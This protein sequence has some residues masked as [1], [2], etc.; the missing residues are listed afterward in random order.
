MEKTLI[1]DGHPV[2]FRST[3]A[4]LLRYKAQFRRDALKDMA[5]LATVL[6]SIPQDIDENDASQIEGVLEIL[7]LQTFF[8]M[9]WV[10]AKTADPSI[11]T[12][13]VWLDKFG[14]FPIL[15]IIGELQ[16]LLFSSIRIT[17]KN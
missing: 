9:V 14:E 11:P 1:I 17:K 13:E 7:D 6:Q 12:P 2:T 10:L 15:D 4:F 3:G 5:R 16:E 8:D